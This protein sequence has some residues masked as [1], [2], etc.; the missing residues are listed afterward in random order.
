MKIQDITEGAVGIFGRAKGKVTRKYRCTSGTRKGRIVAK[1]S[2]C[3]APINVKSKL[4]MKKTRARKG[5]MMGV[6]AK[7]TKRNSPTSRTINRL[8]KT[9]MKP[10]KRST[11]KRKRMK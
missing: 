6:K 9:R 3:N 11:A 10:T 1:A 2:T 7:F 8:N 5:S 4:A